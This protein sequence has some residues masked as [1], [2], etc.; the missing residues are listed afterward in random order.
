MLRTQ[1]AMHLMDEQ[2]TERI[3]APMGSFMESNG[4]TNS[5]FNLIGMQI[6]PDD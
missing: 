5:P 4:G 1:E 3:R 2:S 6:E